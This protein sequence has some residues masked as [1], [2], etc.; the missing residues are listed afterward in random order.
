M[1]PFSII[2][3]SD[4]HYGVR[5]NENQTPVFNGF[6]DDVKRIADNRLDSELYLFCIGD[7]VQ[8]ADNSTYYMGFKERILNPIIRNCGLSNNNILLLPGN[9]DAQRSVIER[10][11]DYST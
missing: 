11:K 7:L 8:A 5:P 9:H 4:I 2:L 3:F 6:I 10:T 1:K